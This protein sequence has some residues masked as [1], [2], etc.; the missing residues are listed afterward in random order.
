ML[1]FKLIIASYAA[2]Y[3]LFFEENR[4]IL[5]FK[6]LHI[7]Y[8]ENN[9]PTFPSIFRFFRTF[10]VVTTTILLVISSRGQESAEGKSIKVSEIPERF[11][12]VQ[13]SL[14]YFWQAF[15][16]GALLSGE[17]QYLQ[18][19]LNLLING[20]PF[21][22]KE[23]LVREPGGAGDRIDLK[24][25]GSRDS[26]SV[27]RDLW[28]D[29]QRSGVRILDTF[30]N[31]SGAAL[32]LSI[33][34]RTTYPFA[35]Q[36]LHGTGGALLSNDP[37]LALG[38]GDSSLEVHFSP[39][40]GRYDTLLLLGNEKSQERPELKTSSNL[41]ELTLTYTLAIPA[42]E[43]RSL[44]H[45]ILQRNLP[46]VTK[47]VAALLPFLQRDQLVDP[48]VETA[49]AKTIVNFSP[50]A[51]PGDVAVPG[52]LKN[53]IALN[54]LTDQIGL[55]R[56]AEDILW[57]SRAN[58]LSGKISREGDLTIETAYVGVQK[59]PLARIAAIQGGSSSG[60]GDLIYLR[61]GRVFAGTI[62]EGNI[63]WKAGSGSGPEL[64]EELPLKTL[65]LLFFATES[66]D[67][68]PPPKTTHF[69]QLINGS[70]LAIAPATGESVAWLTGWGA[71]VW[72]WSDLAEALRV[73]RPGPILRLRHRNG[74]EIAAFSQESNLNLTKTDGGKLEVPGTMVDRVWNS[75]SF[76]LSITDREEELLEFAEVPA[77]RGPAQGF[78]LRDNQFLE[79]SFLEPTLS[80]HA[81]GGHLTLNT[82]DI[83][84]MN[85]SIEPG[86]ES[87]VIV[88]LSN[89]EKVSGR[90]EENYLKIKRSQNE[91]EIPVGQFCGYRRPIQP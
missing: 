32:T 76:V 36:S 59:V 57:I 18:S 71:E 66:G 6:A 56:R 21:A 16:N 87:E 31:T 34:L 75:G 1:G 81:E 5:G 44:L 53:L 14:G 43:T 19:G 39:L 58:Q 49:L 80:L 25:S 2:L 10:L 51:F 47:D 85:R 78:L 79:G 84:E 72:P 91:I 9:V 67:G 15:G 45:W 83:A 22:P 42:G 48:G 40:E 60:R 12:Q 41:R 11:F 4:G 26:F 27:S 37:L 86:K 55:H 35:W 61:D 3:P 62:Q 50:T 8:T 38:A 13:D 7:R 23:A 88:V 64:P 70:V 68:T 90:I 17:A 20:E 33:S 69:L 28:F 54:L 74:S 82:G 89:G 73:N 77:G 30:K 29:T 24:L 52:Q 63:R 46:D 65:H